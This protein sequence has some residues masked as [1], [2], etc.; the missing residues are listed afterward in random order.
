MHVAI[1]YLTLISIDIL[2]ITRFEVVG[3]LPMSYFVAGTGASFLI[4]ICKYRASLFFKLKQRYLIILFLLNILLISIFQ[5]FTGIRYIISDLLIV[6][7]LWIKIKLAL[8]IY[9]S[10]SFFLLTFLIKIFL[11][12]SMLKW[13]LFSA[14][15]GFVRYGIALILSILPD[16]IYRYLGILDILMLFGWLMILTTLIKEGYDADNLVY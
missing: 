11:Y 2:L 12:N 3:M 8:N 15:I 1:I 14:I 10:I 7:E 13:L 16:L 6:G 4:F 5:L 9:M